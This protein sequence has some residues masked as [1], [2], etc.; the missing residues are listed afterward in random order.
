MVGD[1]ELAQDLLQEVFLKLWISAARLEE[2]AT[3]LGP[4]LVTIA[5]DHVLDY[6]KSR[7]NRSAMKSTALDL[8]KL[9]QHVRLP[10]HDFVFDERVG[11]LRSGLDRLDVRQ[12]RVLEWA[13][14]EGLTQTKMAEVLNLPLGTVKSCVRTALRNLKKHLEQGEP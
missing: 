1:A 11:M 6:L 8:R 3:A 14:F 13:Y 9:P 4:W 2:G 5:R 12:R 7:E 10:E